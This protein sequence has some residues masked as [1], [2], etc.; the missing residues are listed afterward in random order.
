[1][2]KALLSVA[3]VVAAGNRVVF[4]SDGS[5]IEDKATKERMW[6]KESA[7]MYMLKVW[8]KTR[9]FRGGE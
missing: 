7:G 3:K 4:D 2:N 6:L 9:V 5:Y 1:M 8:V